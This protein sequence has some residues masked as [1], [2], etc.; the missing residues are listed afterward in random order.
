MAPSLSFIIPVL[1]EASRIAGLLAHLRER[2][3]QAE[4]VV[5]DGGSSDTTVELAR[6][7]CD[8]LCSADAGR[9]RQMNAGAGASSGDYLLFLHA[10]TTPEIDAAALSDA[11]PHSPGWGFSPVRL[12]GRH[13]AFRVIEWF[14]NRRSRLT[15]IATGDQM[16]FL[17]RELFAK[18]GGYADIPLMEDVELCTRLR[19]NA[20][21]VVL[22]RPVVTSTRRWEGRGIVRTVWLMWRLR[23]AYHRGASPEA[24]WAQYY[25]R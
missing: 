17:H 1:D 4:L 5:V 10:D 7:L 21:P 9:A 3:P 11:L 8:V 2:Y 23:L 18:Q 12:S 22:P 16:L 13:P 14:M 15:R 20:D 19:V 24:L 25:G 6:P